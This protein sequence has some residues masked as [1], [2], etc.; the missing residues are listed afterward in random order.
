MFK[1]ALVFSWIDWAF[2]LLFFWFLLRG[3]QKGLLKAVGETIRIAAV[4]FCALGYFV[5]G[6]KF[7]E[8]YTLIPFIYAKLVA[9]IG[10]AF[11]SYLLIWLAGKIVSLIVNIEFHS[12]LERLG[13]MLIG[14][15]HYTLTLSFIIMSV[16]LLPVSITHDVV[17]KKSY[18]GKRVVRF[19]VKKYQ[20]VIGAVDLHARKPQLG[21]FGKE[22]LASS[23]DE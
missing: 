3:F 13:G 15:V 16:M 7:I 12:F 11:V 5:V 14:G 4:L 22:T 1:L 21:D 6:A 2:L 10:I 20:Q 17:Y 9:F 18:L 23:I 8:Q 19:W